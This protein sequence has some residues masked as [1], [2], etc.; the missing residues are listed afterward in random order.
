[1]QTKPTFNFYGAKKSN[2]S[3]IS[4]IP[5][6]SPRLNLGYSVHYNLETLKRQ[7]EAANFNTNNNPQSGVEDNGKG[8]QP[9]G[10][11]GQCGNF[12]SVAALTAPNVNQEV[13]YAPQMD[14]V[15]GLQDPTRFT[16]GGNNEGVG[17]S[18]DYDSVMKMLEID[19]FEELLG[20]SPSGFD[21]DFLSGWSFA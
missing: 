3:P 17:G 6:T 11:E 19:E 12:T 13:N 14:A 15:R 1:M 7:L 8:K 20:P 2:F 21:D 9:L 16:N 10:L 18:L 4:P 5:L